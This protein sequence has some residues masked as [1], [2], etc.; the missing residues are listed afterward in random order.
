M[1]MN[2]A[3]VKH[4]FLLLTALL[5]ALWNGATVIAEPPGDG[6]TGT[7]LLSFDFDFG[8]DESGKSREAETAKVTGANKYRDFT[9]SGTYAMGIFGNA[10]GSAI[11]FTNAPAADALS[12]VYSHTLPHG[13]RAAGPPS[14][15]QCGVYVNGT[16]VGTIK[17]EDTG[18]SQ[19]PFRIATWK[20]RVAGTVKLQTD[21][22]DLAVNRGPCGNVDRVFFGA[23]EPLP[24]VNRRV[25]LARTL[26]VETAWWS[27]GIRAPK[28][29]RYHLG[30]E[31]AKGGAHWGM[32]FV[33]IADNEWEYPTMPVGCRQ[34]RALLLRATDQRTG[35]KG[36]VMLGQ[37]KFAAGWPSN[38]PAD[39]PLPP[40]A[41]LA[42][43]AF[44]GRHQH[45]EGADTWYPSWTPDGTLYSP[46]TDGTVKGVTSISCK[47]DATTGMAKIEG[48]DPLHLTVNAIGTYVS[49]PAPY[50]TRYP[51]ASLVKDGRWYFGTYIINNKLPDGSLDGAAHI[52]PFVG[53]RWSKDFGKTWTETPCTPEKNLF[54]EKVGTVPGGF[55]KIRM[56]SPHV[57]DFGR[58]MEH[59][60]DGKMYLVAHGCRNPAALNTWILG[61]EINLARVAPSP[62]NVND[63][64]QYEFFAGHDAQGQPKW[65][66]NFAEMQPLFRWTR[67]CGCV[68]IT[69]NAPLKKYL[70]CVSNGAT[71][72]A[73][74]DTFILEA[75]AITGPWRMVAYLPQFGRQAYF[76]NI[77]SKFI[78][79]DGRTAWLCYSGSWTGH[80]QNPLGSVYALCLHEMKLLTKGTKRK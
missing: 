21:A 66:R 20:G 79:A 46:F 58:N 60:P 17:F 78:S 39:C 31:D 52:G 41:A 55:A 47:P 35:L 64:S 40:S 72:D 45:Y 73:T 14:V 30:L 59:S 51:C 9:A 71:V 6:T 23:L 22:E 68:T 7:P 36:T 32:E 18:A 49:R 33:H 54:G 43:L 25:A 42:G 53:F 77:P 3:T 56:G 29:F 26:P 10:V 34:V 48:D 24:T 70:M 57:V 69:Y 11:E 75:D 74:F 19:T 44:T 80:Q 4:A 13:W 67:R 8:P 76:V 28:G 5:L 37:V 38:P 12:V 61:D 27:C 63:L 16:R 62:E 2:R 15:K 1:K 65:T 50:D